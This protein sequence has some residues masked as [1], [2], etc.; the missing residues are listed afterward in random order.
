MIENIFRI[1]VMFS[2]I[3]SLTACG[4]VSGWLE[5]E[6]YEVPP[7]ELTEFTQEFVPS[8]AWSTDTGGS[9][10]DYNNLAAWIQGDNVV[11]ID[12]EGKVNSYNIKSGK[13]QWEVALKVPVATGVGGGDGLIIIGTKKGE[14]LALDETNGSL[15]WEAKLS[16]E[17]LAPA[18]VNLGV[19]VASTADGRMTGLSVTDGQV[20]WNYQRAVPLL[21]LRG[22][23]AP[24]IADD[25]VISGYANGKLIA[26][27]ILDGKVMWEKSIAVPRGRTE[28]DRLVDIDA[29]PVVVDNTV[30]V[31]S[32]HGRI[33]AL[34][35]NDGSILWAR[36][37]SSRSGLDVAANDAVYVSDDMSNVWALQDGSG[38]AL[39]RQ[40][41]LLRRQLTAPVVVGD[42]VI[43][44][45]FEGYVHWISRQDGR[46]TARV[47]V[48]DS[49]IRSKPVV[50]DDLV[51]VTA[52]D[53]KLTAFR[54]K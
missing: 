29:D 42:N 40:T 21:S 26:L 14:L 37:M 53:G 51:F 3:S 23:S 1:A 4:T 48:T 36:E 31:V 2:L 30:Y 19:V 39:W 11:A 8:I 47:K 15:L 17:V 43:V 10:D 20:L 34:S 32:Y 33:A 6:V 44:G 35:L 12:S 27:S 5:D 22:A 49:A 13:R 7:T 41:R 18:K 16:S 38:D 28:L 45:D 50:S 25:K 52:A 24:V 54:I 9:D 46:F